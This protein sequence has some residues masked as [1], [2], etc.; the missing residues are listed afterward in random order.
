MKLLK[1]VKELQEKNH[2]KKEV[3]EANKRTMEKAQ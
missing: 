1:L 3:Q 2:S